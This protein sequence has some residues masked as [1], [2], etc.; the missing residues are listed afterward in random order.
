MVGVAVLALGSVV[1]CSAEDTLMTDIVR[2]QYEPEASVRPLEPRYDP[3]E[4]EVVIPTPAET[5]P[6]VDLPDPVAKVM[7][8]APPQPVGRSIAGKA[9][10]YCS[11]SKPI[12]HYAYPPGSMVAAAC[13]KL[14]QAMGADWRGKTVTVTRKGWAPIRVKLVDYCASKT[15]T[16]DL[17]YEP[18]SRLGG[19]GVLDVTV[20]WR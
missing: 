4:A 18:M 16:I 17:Y 10:W 8:P 1:A 9:S 14:R 3:I 2:D 6:P 5:R 20:T 11:R 15:K 12:C 7:T 19:T 13:A